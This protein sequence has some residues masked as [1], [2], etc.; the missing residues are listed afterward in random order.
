MSI[1]RVGAATDIGLVRATNQDNLLVAEPLFAVADGMGGHAAGEV[2]SETAVRALEVAYRDTKEEEPARLGEATR[3]ANTAV[4]DRA[5][6]DPDL[7]GMGTT[8]VA[9]AFANGDDRLAIANVGD[10]RAYRWRKG[11]LE[12]LTTDHNLVQELME[13]GLVSEEEAPFHPQRNVVTRALGVDADVDVDV[14]E[15]AARP[16]DRFL[17]CSDGLGL[18]VDETEVAAVLGRLP[19]PDEAAHQLVAEA[20][21]NGGKDNVTVVVVDVVDEKEGKGF[22]TTAEATAVPAPHDGSDPAQSDGVINDPSLRSAP[23]VDPRPASD[24]SAPPISEPVDPPVT[25]SPAATGVEPAPAPPPQARA[26]TVRVVLFVLALVAILIVAG[27]VVGWYARGS[28]YVG[29]SNGR[30]VIFQGRPGGT[31]W[32]DPTVKERTALSPDQ[33]LPYQLSALHA[34]QQESSL[35][36][37]RAYVNRLQTTTTTTTTTVPPPLTTVPA[38]PL[39]PSTAPPTPALP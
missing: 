6:S 20:R 28:Y 22:P 17:L 3:A 1:L 27:L 13:E 11:Q 32:F 8:L 29:L 36:A 4:W 24:S 39:P 33:L 21:H 15:A 35:S 19:D 7:R 37:A 23:A 16:G 5:R 12:Q 34:G 31:L 10:S 2:A 25:P 14:I 26:L 18:E 9:I 38:F 30:V